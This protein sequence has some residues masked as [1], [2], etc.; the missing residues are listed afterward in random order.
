MNTRNILTNTACRYK[1]VVS[2]MMMMMTMVH[3]HVEQHARGVFK[4]H[5]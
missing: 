5:A 3:D 2:M 4:Q 1:A